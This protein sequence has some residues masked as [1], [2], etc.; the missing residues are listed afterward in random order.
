MAFFKRHWLLVVGSVVLLCVA[1]GV[2]LVRFGNQPVEPKTV[3]VLPKPNPERAEILKGAL[4][5]PKSA[6]ATKASNERATTE[7]T[8][9]ASLKADSGESSSQENDF[10]DEDLESMLAALDEKTTEEMGD[11]PPVPDGFPFTPVW[12]HTAGYKKGD[13]YRHEQI[14][15]VLIKLWNGSDHDFQGG[16]FDYA[17]SKVYPV[18]PDVFY[19]QWEETVIDNGDGNPFPI[20]YIADAIGPFAP[21]FDAED[22]A[23]GRF[24]A[25]YPDMKFIPFKQAGYDPYTF[26]TKND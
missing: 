8:T 17:N 9:T 6:Y 2:F 18:Y 24:E 7:D 21:E 26:L 3:Y 22:V 13:E 1:L 10:E 25:K 4:Q 11:F 19:V 12:I 20:R 23:S 5:P 15:R 16:I 14:A